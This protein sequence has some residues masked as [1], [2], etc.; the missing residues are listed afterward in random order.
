MKKI[1]AQ[2]MTSLVDLWLE[3]A[4]LAPKGK[5]Y[6]L[7]ND[8]W[9]G[10]DNTDG[11]CWVEE[12]KTEEEVIQWLSEEDEYDMNNYSLDSETKEEIECK[13]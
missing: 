8:V 7:D 1:T 9:V 13:H 5:F 6:C 10:C 12:F 2:A 4:E 3:D 11:Y